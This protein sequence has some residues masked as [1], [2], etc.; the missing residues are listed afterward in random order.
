MALT[1]GVILDEKYR[2]LAP[3]GEG[4][5]G[6]VFL[7]EN[8]RIGRRVAVKVL[9]DALDD[10]EDLQERLR[11][12]AQLT[13]KIGSLHVVDVIDF[14]DLPVSAEGHHRHYMVMEHLEGFDL[15]AR[16]SKGGTLPPSI[17]SDY[18]VQVLGA[19]A[20]A[21]ALG[22][23]HH[24]LKPENVFIIQR[25]DRDF[26]KVLDFGLASVRERAFLRS[27]LR[28]GPREDLVVGTPSYMA[29]EK[30]RGEQ[31]D[32]RADIYSVGVLLYESVTGHRPYATGSLAERVRR[33]VEGPPPPLTDFVP[34]I[35]P[36]F[37]AIVER[38]MH[39][40]PRQRF[41]SAEALAAA[42]GGW[43]DERG[44]TED[45]LSTD[46]QKITEKRLGSEP[47]RPLWT[48][49]PRAEMR[50]EVRSR[51][52]K[53]TMRERRRLA[54]RLGALTAIALS[55]LIGASACVSG[56]L[57]SSQPPATIQT[58]PLAEEAPYTLAPQA[59]LACIDES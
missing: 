17:A 15:Q 30:A 1:P 27:T 49:A 19:L 47:P 12:E 57:V 18:A 37:L 14:G 5:M 2:I 45:R 52:S 55:M 29:P 6:S 28:G 4:G 26:I 51:P 38:A 50:A 42:L 9:H 41:Q 7:A 13:V 22:I 32:V 35:D 53:A 34:D 39:R 16:L 8:V 40:D 43:R 3:I 56:D 10:R 44:L 36:G 31:A 24:D 23:V 20:R 11:Q 25:D 33:L 54:K 21:H 58:A 48:P 46:I 59:V